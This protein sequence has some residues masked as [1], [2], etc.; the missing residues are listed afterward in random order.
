MLVVFLPTVD[1]RYQKRKKFTREKKHGKVLRNIPIVQATKRNTILYF[2][3]YE[4]ALR[5]IH[6]ASKQQLK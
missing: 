1:N 2:K 4:K 5:N 6:I 3:C